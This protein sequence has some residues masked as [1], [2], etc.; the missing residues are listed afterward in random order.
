MAEPLSQRR[1]APPVH[2]LD[3]PR[4]SRVGR[5]GISPRSAAS[6]AGVVGHRRWPHR[7]YK[8]LRDQ[9]GQ[10]RERMAHLEGLLEGLREA[11]TKRAA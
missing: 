7:R 6:A 10:L 1:H 2:V 3:F 9:I 4:R 8:D 5:I 11:I